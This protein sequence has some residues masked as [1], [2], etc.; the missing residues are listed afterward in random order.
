MAAGTGIKIHEDISLVVWIGILALLFLAV[1][2]HEGWLGGKSNPIQTS[3]TADQT[4]ATGAADGSNFGLVDWLTQPGGLFGSS[5][6]SW[7]FGTST[8]PPTNSVLTASDTGL[9]G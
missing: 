4:S 5:W 6:F 8:T 7:I 2:I 1:A 3:A 9:G